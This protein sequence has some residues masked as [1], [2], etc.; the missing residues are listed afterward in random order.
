MVATRPLLYFSLPGLALIIGFIFL[1]RQKRSSSPTPD[2]KRERDRNDEINENHNKSVTFNN[3]DDDD[4][5]LKKKNQ[6]RTEKAI[7][8]KLNNSSCNNNNSEFESN[9]G[10]SAP[11]NITQGMK[12]FKTN[13]I[14]DDDDIHLNTGMN[15]QHR[16]S[17]SMSFVRS[18]DKEDDEFYLS[19]VDLP[20]SPNCN[21]L[22][23][24]RNN[25]R[26]SI[27][28]PIII[29]ATVN[30]NISLSSSF[31]E[32]KYTEESEEIISS[33]SQNQQKEQQQQNQLENVLNNNDDDDA[34]NNN[35]TSEAMTKSVNDSNNLS[36][37]SSEFSAHSGDSGKGSSLPHS[38][39]LKITNY[40][41]ILPT[42]LIGQL[43]GRKRTHI[44]QIK[45]KSGAN[46]ILKSHSSTNRM[47]ICSIKGTEKEI[48]SALSLIRARF[49][50][51][52]YPHLT[53]QKI[54]YAE[55]QSI[56]QLSLDYTSCLQVIFVFTIILIIFFSRRKTRVDKGRT[57]IEVYVK[58][59]F[60]LN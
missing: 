14:D 41:F 42:S 17:N 55:P 33:I 4:E 7:S 37:P 24:I 59:F 21:N 29:K 25:H 60:F 36:P 43:C 31:I 15:Y 3:D 52:R 57:I 20:D 51:K 40:D 12:S 48:N 44:N 27:E 56:V 53:L 13:Y 39:R 9:L 2:E 58:H 54:E 19:S 49:P 32:N 23:K 18:F 50:L 35:I 34:N 8:I 5:I 30:P 46:I 6:N 38:D 47:K 11:I 26:K 10:K 28:E 22:C 45:T 16:H 1:R